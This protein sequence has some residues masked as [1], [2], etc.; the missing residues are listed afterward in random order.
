[1]SDINISIKKTLQH[2]GGYT[3]NSADAGGPT[4][5]GITSH[6]LPE[7][8]IENL[9]VDEAVGYYREHYV[10]PLYPQIQNQDVLDKLFDFGVLFGVATA[11]IQLQRI[12]GVHPTGFFG[13]ET[14]AAVN[15][16]GDITPAYKQALVSHVQDIINTHPEDEAFYKGWINRINS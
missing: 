7:A 2:E 4:K 5:Y 16:A 12:L 10:K 6:D 8:N 13:S 11:T 3:N 1:M 15:Q 14:L 9:T